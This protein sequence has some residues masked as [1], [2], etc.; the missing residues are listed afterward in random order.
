MKLF[1]NNHDDQRKI[2]IHKMCHERQLSVVKL[3]EMCSLFTE[4]VSSLRISK[5]F[6]RRRGVAFEICEIHYQ[7]NM[8]S[9]ISKVFP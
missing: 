9:T 2:V 3:L 8:K 4:N 5:R 6:L 1:T 7:F